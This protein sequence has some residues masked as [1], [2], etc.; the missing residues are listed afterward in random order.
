MELVTVRFGDSQLELIKS[1]ASLDGI[2]L[3]QFVRDAAFARAVIQNVRR[4]GVVAQLLE[5]VVA[6]AE[7]D[8]GD[9]L[10]EQL[11]NV[12]GAVNEDPD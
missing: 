2:S 11:L 4:S 1:E 5:A 3:S 9:A 6:V 7:L 10:A 8:G 12:L